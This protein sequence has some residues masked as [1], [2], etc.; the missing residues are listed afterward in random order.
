[1]FRPWVSVRGDCGT[2]VKTS[3]FEKLVRRIV[4]VSVFDPDDPNVTFVVHHYSDVQDVTP[5]LCRLF[6]IHPKF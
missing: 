5:I 4:Y 2:T 1:M 3:V 6:T